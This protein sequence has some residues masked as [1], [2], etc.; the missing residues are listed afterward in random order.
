MPSSPAALSPRLAG[1]IATRREGHSL[2]GEFYKDEEVYR[3]D[4]H[5]IWRRFWLFAGHSCQI[6]K[7]GDFFT[8]ELDADPLLIIRGDDGV[9]R[10]FYNVCRHRGTVVCSE[11]AGHVRRLVCPYHQWVYG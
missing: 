9:I 6:P 1:L 7:P 4:L 8:L 3:A 11:E 2:P 10:A 5:G